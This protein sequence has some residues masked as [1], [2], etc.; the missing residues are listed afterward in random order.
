M[1]AIRVYSTMFSVFFFAN[2]FLI[3][4]WVVLTMLQRPAVSVRVLRRLRSWDEQSSQLFILM[5]IVFFE[6]LS[7]KLDRRIGG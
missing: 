4:A 2:V 7:Y 5:S 6:V 1:F 3:A